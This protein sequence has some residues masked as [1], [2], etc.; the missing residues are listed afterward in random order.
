MSNIEADAF[1][2]LTSLE[3]LDLSSNKLNNLALRLPNSLKYFSIGSN[4]LKYWPIANLPINLEVL[5]IQDNQLVEMC[6]SASI[7]ANKIE[8]AQLKVL[9]VSQNRIESIPL[10]LF[11]PLLEVLDASQ[12]QFLR[13][14][15]YL[16]AQTPSLQW[17]RFRLNPIKEIKFMTKLSVRKLDF[18]GSILLSELD[19]NEFTSIGMLFQFIRAHKT[20]F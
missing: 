11:F 12:N 13:I 19:A 8:F 1:E 18:S 2:S 16:G 4:Q 5:E 3:T 10:T 6:N 7:G 9:N 17:L 14:P 15:Q 20:C